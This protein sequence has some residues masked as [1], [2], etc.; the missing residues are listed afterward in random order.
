MRGRGTSSA[1][2]TARA[3][4][5]AI[6]RSQAIAELLARYGHQGVS[7]EQTGIPPDTWDES[8]VPPPQQVMLRAYLS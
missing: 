7:I 1:R 6:S 2:A 5:R 8:E 3:S 4:C